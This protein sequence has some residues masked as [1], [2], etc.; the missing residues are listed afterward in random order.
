MDHNPLQSGENLAASV[1]KTPN[2]VS[3]S[4]LEAKVV[5]QEFLN[6]ALMPHLTICILLLANGF[7]VVGTSAP[8]D[9]ENFNAEAGRD[10]ARADALK[11]IW[12]LEGYLLREK[13]A[14]K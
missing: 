8:A 13:L 12:P 10:F 1:Q 7:S 2:R 3:L 9:P 14:A 6:P 11:K 5:G 4:D